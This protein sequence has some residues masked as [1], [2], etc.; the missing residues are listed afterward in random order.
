MNEDLQNFFCMKASER[1]EKIIKTR[2]FTFFGVY[3]ENPN[4]ISWIVSGRRTER[5]PFLITDTAIQRINEALNGQ[6]LS[7]KENRYQC[8]VISWGDDEEIEGYILDMMRLIAKNLTD[9]Q[10]IVFDATL[11]DDIY[12]AEKIAYKEILNKESADFLGIDMEKLDTEDI[13]FYRISAETNLLNEIKKEFKEEFIKFL[14]ST[15]YVRTKVNGVDS[16]V[17]KGITFKN[18]FGCDDIVNLFLK[19]V[20]AHKLPV[21]ESLGYRVYSIVKKDISKLKL[22]IERQLV[23]YTVYAPYQEDILVEKEYKFQ[24]DIIEVGQGYIEALKEV[25]ENRNE[26][27]NELRKIGEI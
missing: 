11:M 25:H 5:N 22:L 16:Y 24:L 26:V 10:Q 8:R 23:Y 3:P 19:V 13:P 2:G 27:F 21:E 1:I 12:F 7:D 17:N 9:E 4:I 14:D 20:K 18:Q 6:E 15:K